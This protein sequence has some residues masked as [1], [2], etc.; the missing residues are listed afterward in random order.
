MANDFEQNFTRRL[1]RTFLKAF[2]T[3]RVLSKNVDTQLLEGKFNPA[4]GADVDFKRP[5]DYRSVRT[6]DGD[7]TAET[8]NE[9]LTGKATGTVQPYF[10]V[11]VDYQE[12]D[13]AIKGDQLDQLLD[14]MGQR[15][16]T[17]L[18]V[19]F[20]AYMKANAGLTSGAYGSPVT[21]WNHVAEGGAVLE[22]T[23][24]PKD[25]NWY[26]TVNPYT[27]TDLASNQRS[28]GAGGSAGS[29]INEAHRNATITDNFAGMRVM[30]GTTLSTLT[31]ANT[32]G[33]T[34]NVAAT[35]TATYAAHS[36]TMIQSI[37]VDGVGTFTGTIPAGTM[38]S[39]AACNRLNLSTRQPIINAAGTQEQW[40]G[41]LTADAAFTGGAGT[42][43]VSGPAIFEA[44]GQYNTVDRGITSGDAIVF[45]GTDDTLY[46]PNLFWHKQAFSIGSVPIKK[47]HSTD[48]IATTKDGL[49]IRVS[50]GADVRANKQIVRFDLRPAYGTMN[51]FFAGQGWGRP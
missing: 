50:K 42:I 12:A 41:H 1:A 49:Q 2:E 40:R 33:T 27:Q 29:I 48:T 14:P 47:L 45:A 6:T 16:V 39:V 13:E 15:I 7:V 10:T 44:L 28:L 25:G 43:L 24:V 23:G 37:S 51:P 5:T 34:G 35:P 18:E 26:Y 9:I 21:T 11:E 32:G 38:V 36:S 46:Q 30:S 20:A 4:S 31:T 17:D 22:T 8:P 19:D 3:K